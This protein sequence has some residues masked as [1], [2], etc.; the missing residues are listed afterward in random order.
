MK[1]IWKEVPGYPMYDVSDNGRVRSWRVRGNNNGCDTCRWA[2]EPTILKQ[3]RR[4]YYLGVNI[5]NT[6][7]KSTFSVH[8]LV[9]TTFH[10]LGGDGMVCCH[11]NGERD[12]NRASNL[13]W[14]TPKENMA[15]TLLHGTRNR[16]ARNGHAK[17][18]DAQ[19]LAIRED[20]RPQPVIAKEYGLCQQSVSLIKLRKN[21]AWLD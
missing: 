4:N 10:G 5:V 6:H 7:G 9:L 12:D 8:K 11:N 16:G 1:E 20:T 15:D 17:L 14:G 3:W 21:W 18:S 19:V 13:R 2:K